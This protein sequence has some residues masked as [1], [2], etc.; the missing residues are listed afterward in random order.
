MSLPLLSG[1]Q[2][3]R[4]LQETRTLL[5]LSGPIVISQLAQT[6]NGFVDTVMSGQA[7]ATDLAAV[8]LGTSIWL[9][10]YL[11]I[12]GIMTATSAIVSHLYGA[13]RIHEI[14]PAIHQALWVSLPLGFLACI[15]LRHTTPLLEYLQV[16]PTL[17]PVTQAYLDGI[18][19]GF[20]A[21]SVFL[22][23]RF[24]AEGMGQ[25]RI[26][27]MVSVSG[28]L[29]NI[30]LNY[31]L[32]FGKFG[33]PAMGGPGCGWATAIVMML[34]ATMMTLFSLRLDKR[35]QCNLSSGVAQPDAHAIRDMLKLG[36]P[37]GM[38]IF[39]EVSVF[40][41]ISL[42]IAPLGTTVIAGHQV[43]LNVASLVFMIPLSLSLAFG[44]RLGHCVGAG[45][46]TALDHVAIAGVTLMVIVATL[47]AVVM[48]LARENIASLYTQDGAVL[49]LASQLLTL[50]ALFQFSDGLQAGAG[51][52]L[53]GLKDTRYPM[54]I[55]LVSYW[56]IALSIGYA[57]AF[58]KFNLPALGAKGFWIGLFAGLS[59]AA[60]LLNAR[61][62]IKLRATR[63]T[64]TTPSTMTNH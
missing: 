29:A 27:M 50:A 58:G 1:L 64:M 32:I 35:L 40:C 2:R 37:I 36:I 38:A 60:V 11:F 61:F 13:S 54:I 7:G 14:G 53:R 55:T 20:P 10:I 46:R 16:E 45:D 5:S 44:V 17:V 22:A 63:N 33:L 4:L 21:I 34:M 56:V 23:L 59:C 26:V 42:L 48:S 30:G 57:L 18:S 51:G 12:V 19:W 49:A 52:A 41:V 31:L 62:F 15:A 39:F 24:F 47:N 8:A 6:A 25:P 28:L 9:P 43:A 3:P